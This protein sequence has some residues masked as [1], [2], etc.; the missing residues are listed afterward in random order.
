MVILI[1]YG[2]KIPKFSVI[3][4][5]ES[6]YFLPKQ[7]NTSSGILTVSFYNVLGVIVIKNY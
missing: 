4:A 5:G 2:D 3:R 1:K 6:S 7:N